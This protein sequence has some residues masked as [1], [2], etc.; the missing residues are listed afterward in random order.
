MTLPTNQGREG[1]VRLRALSFNVNFQSGLE[2]HCEIVIPVGYLSKPAFNL[3]LVEFNNVSTG[4]TE[5]G[6]KNYLTFIKSSK[7]FGKIIFCKKI[8]PS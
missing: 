2:P 4:I 7:I 5:R 6:N 8:A 1:F 3:A